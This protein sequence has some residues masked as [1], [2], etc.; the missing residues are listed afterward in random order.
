MNN[1]VLKFKEFHGSNDTTIFW[2]DPSIKKK[3]KER[4]IST[5]KSIT[6]NQMSS[7]SDIM[8]FCETN[9]TVLFNVFVV[10]VV[11]YF[12]RVLK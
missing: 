4:K 7:I 3:Q 9:S 5:F 11:A 12:S 2:N 1:K 10:V 8:T 6:V